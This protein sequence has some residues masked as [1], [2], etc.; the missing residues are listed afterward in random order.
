MPTQKTIS[1][2]NKKYPVLFNKG[3][4]YYVFF[5]QGTKIKKSGPW[6]RSV[7]NSL[8]NEL[9]INSICAWVKQLD[10]ENQ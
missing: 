5:I 9:L 8:R 6:S 10:E 2:K 7:A 4:D 1:E 3:W